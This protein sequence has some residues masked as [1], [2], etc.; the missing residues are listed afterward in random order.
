[1]NHHRIY[2]LLI[3]LLAAL[4]L[5]TLGGCNLSSP[6]TPD[7]AKPQQGASAEVQVEQ[8]N[9][10]PSNGNEE[11][12]DDSDDDDSSASQQSGEE[13]DDDLDFLLVARRDPAEEGVSRRVIGPEGGVLPHA[14][15]RLEVPAGALETP[16]ELTFAVPLS[17]TLM[18]DLGPHGTQF[19]VPVNLVFSYR[20]ADLT[21]VN[22]AMLQVYYYNPAGPHYEAIPTQV[23]TVNMVVI[24]YTD[25]FSRYALIRK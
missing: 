14:A 8:R 25:H 7:A 10:P 2:S 22:P 20:N 3:V 11:D 24:G 6:T 12:D 21:G 4:A 17:D 9:P 19:N 23:D 13:D 18:F 15:H 1:M 16:T 5:L